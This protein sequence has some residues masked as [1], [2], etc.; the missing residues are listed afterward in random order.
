MLENSIFCLILTVLAAVALPGSSILPA[1]QLA[2]ITRLEGKWFGLFG[3]NRFEA[4]YSRRRGA[5]F[6]PP[7]SH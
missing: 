5:R 2:L 1:E 6:P 4:T 7:P 3:N